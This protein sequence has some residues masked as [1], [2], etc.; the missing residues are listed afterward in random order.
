M[1]IR[2]ALVTVQIIPSGGSNSGQSTHQTN[3]ADSEEEQEDLELYPLETVQ[4]VEHQ[5]R[6]SCENDVK[7]M[8]VFNLGVHLV[9]YMGFRVAIIEQS[10]TALVKKISCYYEFILLDI[11]RMG[12]VS[13]L[14]KDHCYHCCS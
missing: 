2:K 4:G 10:H 12:C 14:K 7:G 13:L 6:Q 8:K 5:E 3:A 1:Q 9:S 11:C